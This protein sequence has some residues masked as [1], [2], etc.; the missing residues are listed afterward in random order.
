MSLETTVEIGKNELEKKEYFFR[1]KKISDYN[2]S[3]KHYSSKKIAE[4]Y[5]F[6]EKHLLKGDYRSFREILQEEHE[7]KYPHIFLDKVL[8]EILKT[9]GK[10]LA[11]KITHYLAFSSRGFDEFYY[12][13]LINKK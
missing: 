2:H 5:N 11:K 12:N 10:E 3:G 4:I 1:D 7:E 6:Y 13:N 8:K 9:E